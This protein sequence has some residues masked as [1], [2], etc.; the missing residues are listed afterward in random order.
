MRRVALTLGIALAASMSAGAAEYRSIADGGAVMYDGPSTK[1]RPLF[2]AT[3][4]LP[5]E[6]IS[7][8]GT[9]VKVRD[10]GGDLTWVERKLLTD[11]R[12]VLVSAPLADIRQRAEEQATLVF[13]AAQGVVLDLGDQSGVTPGWVRVK[14]R[15][16]A[17]GFVRINQV[18][19]L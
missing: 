4:N 8:D 15:D 12:T 14:H 16:G 7:T 10:P 5:V 18:W 3:R 19:G 2:V 11:R 17:T 9:W 1:A 6:V 13:Q